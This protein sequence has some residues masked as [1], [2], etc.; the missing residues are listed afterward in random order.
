MAWHPH[1]PF[2]SYEGWAVAGACGVVILST[3]PAICEIV[4]AGRGE[5]A[6]GGGSERT[7]TL[8]SEGVTAEFCATPI[9]RATPRPPPDSPRRT[10]ARRPLDLPCPFG[11][12]A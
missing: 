12:R 6:L 3:G 11:K 8:P 5:G 1:L 4:P 2:G 10:S 9:G 7:F